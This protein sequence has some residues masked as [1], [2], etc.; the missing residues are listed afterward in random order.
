MLTHGN[1]LGLVAA[2]TVVR[3]L[4][5]DDDLVR[6][7][8]LHTG[9]GDAGE[10]GIVEIHDAGCTAVAHAGTETADEL[11]EDRKSTRLNS[12]HGYGS[13]MPSSA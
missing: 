12:S 13:R 1:G 2:D 3:R 8:L 10:L 6:M 4:A 5:G 7:A 9:V 11:V